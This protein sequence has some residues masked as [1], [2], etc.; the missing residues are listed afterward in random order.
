MG[1]A[2]VVEL[3][4]MQGLV[5]PTPS[6]AAANAQN[7]A[8]AVA[9]TAAAAVLGPAPTQLQNGEAARPDNL[10]DPA[11]AAD[12]AIADM[13]NASGP[14]QMSMECQTCSSRRYQDGSDD[15]GVSFKMPTY[16]DPALSAS[17]VLGH[18]NEHVMRNQAKAA[19][20]GD[21]VVSQSV[22]LH[23]D[24]CPECGCFYIAGGTTYTTTRSGGE[25]KSPAPAPTPGNALDT[26]A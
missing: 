16:I 4:T 10:Q 11:I 25:D 6:Y 21:K 15:P 17:A 19:A 12:R 8:T 1:E 2:C 22:I 7:S 13:M 20:E 26:T 14:K 23:G 5:A 18:E 3:G 24:T 9:N